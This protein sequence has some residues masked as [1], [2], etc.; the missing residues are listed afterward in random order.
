VR[1]KVETRAKGWRGSV[2][3]RPAREL[4][5]ESEENWAES[6][7]GESAGVAKRPRGYPTPNLSVTI[8]NFCIRCTVGQG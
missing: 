4:L 7:R 8:R 2:R 1:E 5:R 3:T 6:R